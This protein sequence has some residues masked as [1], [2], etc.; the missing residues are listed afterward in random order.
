MPSAKTINLWPGFLLYAYWHP[1]SINFERLTSPV[2]LLDSLN[3]LNRVVNRYFRLV[4]YG[5]ARGVARSGHATGHRPPATDHRPFKAL[6][7]LER[8]SANA[9]RPSCVACT[10]V[11][12]LAFWNSLVMAR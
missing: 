7:R 3:S 11:R 5:S 2:I 6:S 8:Y 1:A 9:R 10:Q 4:D 12:G